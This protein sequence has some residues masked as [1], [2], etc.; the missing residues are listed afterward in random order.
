M[1]NVIDS[2]EKL[3]H[4]P[5]FTF[6]SGGS[7]LF[8]ELLGPIDLWLGTCVL[9]PSHLMYYQEHSGIALDVVKRRNL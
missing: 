6:F 7:N 8:M 1:I 2:A 5:N 3:M 9:M 4:A